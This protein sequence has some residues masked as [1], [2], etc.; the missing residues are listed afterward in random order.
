MCYI[1]NMKIKLAYPKIP[2]T[3]HC[4][5]KQCIAFEKID[6]TNIHWVWSPQDG[7]HSFGTRRDRYNYSDASL[8][9]FHKDHFGLDGLDDAFQKLEKDL[10]DFLMK[11]F[12]NVNE[13]IVFTEFHGPNSFAG[14]HN[15]QDSKRFVIF[16]VQV[17]GVMLPPEEFIKLFQPF[18]IPK[19]VFQGKFTGQLFV[20]VRNSKYPVKEGVVVK[21]L[22]G[23][24]I[25]MAKIKTQIYLQRLKE[26]FK[27]NWKEY[28]E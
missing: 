27:D 8:A 25:Y 9:E 1:G 7:F 2:D 6:G 12:N 3:L 19:V 13:V 17:D 10:N 24:E 20:D 22:V 14:S 11:H 26:N 18:G 16:D 23:Q 4:P 5:L 15:D 21:G 28:W